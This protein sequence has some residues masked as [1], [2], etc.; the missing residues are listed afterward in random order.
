MGRSLLNGH[1]FFSLLFSCYFEL[2]LIVD[3][4]VHYYYYYD[5]AVVKKLYH[6]MALC[7]VLQ[8]FGNLVTLRWWNDLW[9]NEGF[10][11]YVSFLG[12]DHAEPDWGVVRNP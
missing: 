3:D 10:A 4:D 2:T 12:A 1:I 7:V 9:L 11:T 5:F 6:Y 8:W